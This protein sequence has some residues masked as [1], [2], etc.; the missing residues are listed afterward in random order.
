MVPKLDML[1]H[2]HAPNVE[3]FTLPGPEMQKEPVKKV[4]CSVDVWKT[5]RESKKPWEMTF[6][7]EPFED[8]DDKSEEAETHCGQ[9]RTHVGLTTIEQIPA[10]SALLLSYGRRSNSN[11]LLDYGFAYPGNPYDYAEVVFPD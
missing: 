3:V 9:E 11:L 5:E 10:G 4:K 2:S 1:N 7:D 8:E 6:D